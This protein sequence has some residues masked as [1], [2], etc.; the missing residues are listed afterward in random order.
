MIWYMIPGI[1]L[2]M[3]AGAIALEFAGRNES[4]KPFS[5]HS[6]NKRRWD[7]PNNKDK[8][9]SLVPGSVVRSGVMLGHERF[10]SVSRDPS[11]Q[12]KVLAGWFAA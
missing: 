3:I 2:A 12:S 9:D 10:Y 4:N 11:K 7:D 5:R 8:R 6:L 1:A